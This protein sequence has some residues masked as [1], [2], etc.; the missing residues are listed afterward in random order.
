MN[1]EPLFK[2]H[3]QGANMI[4][5]YS[6]K[7]LL[8]F[9]AIGILFFGAPFNANAQEIITPPAP[10]VPVPVK[11]D[12]NNEVPVPIIELVPQNS[13]Q[14]LAWGMRAAKEQNWSEVRR[15]MSLTKD[16]HIK[17]ALWWRI[18]SDETSDAGFSES[19]DAL[20]RLVGFP[21][22]RD[23]RIRLE[24]NIENYGL[25]TNTKIKFLTRQEP[26][27][28]N[29]GPISGEGQMALAWAYIEAGEKEKARKI[30]SNAWR[31]FRFDSELQAKYLERFG[32][33]LNS[34]DH[35]ERVNMLL[36]LNRQTQIRPLL[37]L[38]SPQMRINANA[39]LG[40]I[41]EEGAILSGPSLND[42]GITYER[43]KKLRK[44]DNDTAALDLLVSTDWSSLPEVAGE[45]LWEERRR[46]LLEAIRYNR[47]NDAYKIM[48]QHGLKSG[49]NAAEGE[50]TAGWI[51][52]RFLKKPELALEHYRKF[53]KLVLTGMSKSRGYYWQGRAYEALGDDKNANDFYLLGANYPTFYYGQLAAARIGQRLGQAAML[54]L[55]PE[56]PASLADKAS[57][58]KQPMMTI[59]RTFNDINERDYFIKFAFALDD[60]LTTNGEHQA[61][62]EYAKSF[63]ENQVGIRVAK[64]GLNRGILATEAAFPV[65]KIPKIEN[66][67]QAEDAFSLAITRQESEFNAKARSHV[68]ALG[69]MQ[70]MPATASS[71]ARKMGVEHQTSW[72]NSRPEHNLMLGSAH[73]ADLIDRFYGSYIL[74]IIAYNAGPGRSSQWIDA[75]GEIRGADSD[76]VID[77]IEKIPF[78][79]T[80]NYVQR[81]LE[82]MQ[83][84]RARLNKDEFPIGVLNDLNR[85]TKPPPVFKI[86]VLDGG[87]RPPEPITEEAK[88]ENKDAKPIEE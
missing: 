79:E 32:N 22:M 77:W 14:A 19:S 68:G 20:Q 50:Q 7:V 54:K 53:D 55:P 88:P 25:N 36:W 72:L 71:Q 62:S 52:L 61:L 73:L 15:L 24:K 23:I 31:K 3:I 17:D 44:S 6:R 86:K 12:F 87:F 9:S 34:S 35:D 13:E 26:R 11:V 81:V 42:L 38:I 40:I 10:P 56:Q 63:G 30:A 46:L 39:R 28:E 49:A 47:W 18:I 16:A 27:F 41:N 29:D 59:A 43:I 76:F 78:S 4:K 83:V 85:G 37:S 45:D 51:A 66:Y 65:I 5:S 33:I 67:H 64:A 80:R 1:C 82:N 74:T 8:Q 2:Q 69:L 60:L 21:N 84:Y 70:F 48:S 58:N 57:L 75:Y